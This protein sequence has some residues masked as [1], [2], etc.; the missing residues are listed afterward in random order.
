MARCLDCE[1][2]WIRDEYEQVHSGH[3]VMVKHIMV[4]PRKLTEAVGAVS[5]KPGKGWERLKI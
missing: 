1:S 5:K 3:Q 2:I 4:D